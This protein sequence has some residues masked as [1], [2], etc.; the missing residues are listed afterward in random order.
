MYGKNKTNSNGVGISDDGINP[1][2]IIRE[3]ILEGEK[4]FEYLET[5]AIY[6]RCL[7]NWQEIPDS[8]MVVCKECG[9]EEEN[10]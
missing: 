3:S 9:L 5:P 8:N 4:G 2:R 10:D 1:P 6:R 7:H